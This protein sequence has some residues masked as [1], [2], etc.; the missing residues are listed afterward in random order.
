M[1][2]LSVLYIGV[3]D[4]LD[5]WSKELA[6]Y[7]V[8]L[9]SSCYQLHL[10][11]DLF[12]KQ[13]GEPARYYDLVIVQN[14]LTFIHY[15][16]LI[17]RFAK[18]PFLF[19]STTNNLRS[20]IAPFDNLFGVINVKNPMLSAFGIPD[21]LQ[22]RLNYPVEKIA[23]YYFYE[24]EP[25]LCRIVYCPTG[26]SI[27]ENDLKLLTF[28]HQTNTSLTIL[29]D[30][31]QLLKTALPP[32]VRVLPRSF[33]FSVY[34]QAH[35]VVASGWDAIRAIAFCKPCIILG[36]YGLGGMVTLENYN[37]LQSIYFQG[38]R[39]GC[40]GEWVPSVLLES[41]IQKVFAFDQEEIFLVL[42]KRVKADYG[43]KE[44]QE[45]FL[46]EIE[47]IITISV[48]INNRKKHLLLKPCLSSLFSL[49]TS[50]GKQYLIRGL[51][52]FGEM[53]QEMI[54]LL[55]QCDGTVSI[56]GLIKGNGYDQEEE[57]ILWLNIYELWK[58][59]LILFAL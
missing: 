40:F 51:N 34:K 28:L 31:Y 47:K 9:L 27:S 2:R 33:W 6:D 14:S 1:K 54:D 23:N 56:Q 53:D 16:K 57:D 44:F 46:Q 45:K 13:D 39:G 49:K 59:K 5:I 43:R 36:D 17:K 3:R 4:G 20:Y 24:R 50:G 41:E 26:N 10:L 42:Q 19:I 38:R 15:N 7:L 37:H 11:G 21:E 30:E 29:S 58:K 52:C 25:E 22:V 32:F 35:L 48:F 12:S 18:C 8:K 55:K